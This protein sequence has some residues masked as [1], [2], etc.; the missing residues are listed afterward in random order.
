MSAVAAVLFF[1]ACAYLGAALF[2]RPAAVPEA[3]TVPAVSSRGTLIRGIAVRTE[4]ALDASADCSGLEDAR[5]V[6]AASLAARGLFD[7]SAVYFDSC[8]GYEALSP[9]MLD[10]LTPESLDGIMAAQPEENPGGR[11]VTERD[12]YIAAYADAALPESGRARF[13]PD[14]M[15]GSLSA[16]IVSS[17]AEGGRFTVLLRLTDGGEAA[18]RLRMVSGEIA[19]AG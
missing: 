1:A 4:L 10:G 12:W 16:E 11:L 17:A 3:E 19:A 9:E 15:S 13:R 2:L 18:L 7:G 6:S 8:D 14:G 5:R